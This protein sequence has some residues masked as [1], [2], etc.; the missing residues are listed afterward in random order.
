MSPLKRKKL[1]KIRLKLDKLDNSLIKLIK[2]RT[3]LVNQVLKLKD[4]KKEIIDNKRIKLIYG[5][6]EK[7]VGALNKGII[8]SKGK[9]IARMDSDDISLPSRLQSQID[10]IEKNS[11]DVCGCHCSYV[12]E[13]NIEK[14]VVRFPLSHDLCF[15]SL[16]IKVPFAH[17]C[18]MIRSKFLKDH[19]LFYGKNGFSIAEDLDL[20]INMSK[21]KVRFGNV[22]EILFKYRITKNSLSKIND[23]KVKNNTKNLT[24][25]FLKINKRKIIGILKVCHANLIQEEE[26]LKARL[27]FKIFKLN[28][29]KNLKTLK[30]R[31]IL[32]GLLSQ[33]KNFQNY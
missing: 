24:R 11:L 31:N 1:N 29:F 18:V 10:H 26:I 5:N 14:K 27:I 6:N 4:K 30:I 15:L 20:W 23:Y 9:F 22:N 21:F 32:Y 13:F 19:D 16:A 3:N 12:D 8:N 2:Q 25:L 7:I 28:L 33:I 17:P